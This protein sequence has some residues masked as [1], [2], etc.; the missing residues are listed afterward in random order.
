MARMVMEK[1]NGQVPMT[2]DE[3]VLLPG[4]GRKQRM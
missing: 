3:L 2:V 1:F 4:V